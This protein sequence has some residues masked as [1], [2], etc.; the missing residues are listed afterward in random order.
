MLTQPAPTT[1][2]AVP[3]RTFWQRADEITGFVLFMLIVVGG[4]VTPFAL[5]IYGLM[6]R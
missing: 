4:V 6:F 1:P 2:T 5:Y 3:A